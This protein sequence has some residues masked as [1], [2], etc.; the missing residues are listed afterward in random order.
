MERWAHIGTLIWFAGTNT[1]GEGRF[2]SWLREN[3]DG[4]TRRGQ[5][6]CS[7][8]LATSGRMAAISGFTPRM[9][10]TRVKLYARTASAISVATFGMVRVRKCVAPMRAL[11]VPKG[12][13]TVSRRR[14]MAFGSASRRRCTASSMCSSS[15]RVMRRS[16]PVVQAV[17]NTQLPHALAAAAGRSRRC[18]S[19][20]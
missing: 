14:R 18:C 11:I 2:G 3:A 16:F 19:D 12:C 5:R 4:L 20:R 9:F 8:I 1:D 17:F 10:T 15:A 6:A 7:V 13:S